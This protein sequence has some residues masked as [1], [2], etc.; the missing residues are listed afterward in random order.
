MDAIWAFLSEPGNQKTLG[1][2][3]GG[4]VVG[5]GGL[6]AVVT[7][8]FPRSSS[9]GATPTTQIT[10]DR[11]GI[12][13][14]GNVTI[15]NRGPSG[16]QIVLLVALVA[17]VLLLAAALAGTRITVSNGVGVGGN[18]ENSEIHVEGGAGAAR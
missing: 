13:A 12:A 8:L 4:L 1:W 18:V 5:A 14:G 10:A 7:R 16:L 15:T 6:W 2:L 11:R 3:G 9:G 17:G